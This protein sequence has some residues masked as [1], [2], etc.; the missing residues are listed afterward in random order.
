MSNQNKHNYKRTKSLMLLT[1]IPRVQ[2]VCELC[3]EAEFAR[4]QGIDPH[5]LHNFCIYIYIFFTF[6]FFYNS[7]AQANSLSFLLK[8][9][10]IN[11][12][13]FQIHIFDSDSNKAQSCIVFPWFL[14]STA[15]LDKQ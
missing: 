9:I 7:Q 14:V 12:Y 2:L 3:V 13:T 1:K 5:F 8:Q 15:N 4:G 6:V 10:S 11:N